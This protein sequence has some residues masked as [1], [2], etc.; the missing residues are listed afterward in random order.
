MERDVRW[1][2]RFEN[3]KRALAVLKRAV[4]LSYSRELTELEKQGL[5]RGFE[6]TFELAWNVMKDYLEQQG[7]TGISGGRD[8]IRKAFN[9]ALI[10][11]GQM[12]LDMIDSR[13]IS[14][15]SY[16]EETAECLA[17]KIKS[18]YYGCLSGFAEKMA[19][20]V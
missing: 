8:A 7:I 5:I 18:N 14:S 20:L 6:F 16:S 19:G 15:L 11:D 3:Y 13:N 1:K 2:Q 12:W 10:T 4:D 9:A 17:G